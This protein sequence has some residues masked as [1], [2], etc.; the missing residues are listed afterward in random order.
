MTTPAAASQL[1]PDGDG[2]FSPLDKASNA[3]TGTAQNPTRPSLNTNKASVENLESVQSPTEG[4]GD[5]QS[6]LSPTTPTTTVGY[7]T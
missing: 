2:L 4:K 6:L 1:P 3:P 7:Y 5:K